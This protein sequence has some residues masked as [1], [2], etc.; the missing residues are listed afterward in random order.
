MLPRPLKIFAL[1]L[2]L[3][4]CSL[5]APKFNRPT[6]T[7]IGIELRGGN[8]LQQNFAVKL[9][10]Q[11]PNDR[12]LPVQGVHA[13]LKVDGELIASGISDRAVVIPAMGESEFY[14]TI[15]ANLA[16]ALLKLAD[17][18]NARAD[19][20][21]YDVTGSASIDLPFLRNLPFHQSGSLKFPVGQ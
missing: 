1:S 21:D 15:A 8:L 12:P 14:L 9:D 2:C 6:V 17:R 3:T 4:A 10:I 19:S 7:V 20:I 5:I 13:E 11:N 16:L 18:A